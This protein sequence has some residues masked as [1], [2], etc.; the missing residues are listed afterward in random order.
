[1]RLIDPELIVMLLSSERIVRSIHWA[2]KRV[3]GHLGGF[4]ALRLLGCFRTWLV[5]SSGCVLL[6]C[7]EYGDLGFQVYD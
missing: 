6:G 1:V 2:W 4:S 7:F 5:D 3:R